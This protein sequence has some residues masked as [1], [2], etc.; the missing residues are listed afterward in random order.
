[1]FRRVV[2][3]VILAA[4]GA[5]CRLAALEDFHCFP[6]CSEVDG[7]MLSLA[8][9]GLATLGGDSISLRLISAGSGFRLEVFDGDT[10]AGDP[11]HWDRVAPAEAGRTRLHFQLLADPRGDGSRL[12]EMGPPCQLLPEQEMP[13]NEWFGVR[14]EDAAQARAEPGSGCPEERYCYRLE[15]RLTRPE[16]AS[17]SNF[18]L[19]TTAELVLDPGAFSF[20]G[21]LRSLA[22]AAVL[23][24]RF[25]LGELEPTRYDGRWDF[26]LQVERPLASLS[27]WDGDFDFGSWDCSRRDRP[28]PDTCAAPAPACLPNTLAG[29]Q[30][31]TVPPWAVGTAARGDGEAL[32]AA[33]GF[34]CRPTG[35][36]PD[37]GNPGRLVPPLPAC[38]SAAGS[39]HCF[40]T[41]LPSV[42]YR[43]ET[44]VGIFQNP[45]PSGNQEWE[46]FRL[47]TRGEVPADYY[48]PRLP[49]G[50]YRLR[51]EG[52][53]ASNLSAL[54]PSVPV[55][56][57]PSATLGGR[58]WLDADGD[59]RQGAGEPGIEDVRLRLVRDTDGDGR[60]VSSRDVQLAADHSGARGNYVFAGLGA[61]PFFVDVVEDTLP[62]G[63]QLTGGNEP[64][65]LPR[66]PYPLAESE[67]HLEADFG[68]FPADPPGVG[69]PGYWK[70][71]PEAWPRRRLQVGGIVR[72][73]EELLALLWARGKGDKTYTLFRQLAAALLNA[74]AGNDWSCAWAAMEAA[75]GWL[76]RHPPGSGVRA[77]HPAWRHAEAWKDE[78]ED[79]NSGRSPCAVARASLPVIP[80]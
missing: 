65:D 22:D 30:G 14:V 57:V 38:P 35:A 78:L 79:Y 3:T 47:E 34:P 29:F 17:E 32:G 70:N 66:G 19:R 51:V 43:L 15:V 74:A 63:L 60:L 31:E 7:K 24:P 61:G 18:K 6:T 48:V 5:S 75:D 25:E 13:D 44:P 23:Y 11:P 41:R 71:H 56:G 27:V 42:T 12:L 72:E 33:D 67:L 16:G 55:L 46:Q 26:R 37:D 10:G 28:D 20:V 64:Y 8:G 73:R 1:M 80:D 77:R 58:V 53:D 50:E 52:L 9:A 59:G 21:A 49:A 2:L 62:R 40:W 45:N 36:P 54:R 76:V 39:G 69:T 4:A 68:Y